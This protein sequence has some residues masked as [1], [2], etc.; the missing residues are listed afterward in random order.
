[1]GQLLITIADLG[2]VSLVDP[3]LWLLGVSRGVPPGELLLGIGRSPSL[4][5]SSSCL[6]LC[7]RKIE[8]FQINNSGMIFLY[9]IV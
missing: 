2:M 6:L 1:M 3:L 4:L 7:W 9:D 8:G 5:E